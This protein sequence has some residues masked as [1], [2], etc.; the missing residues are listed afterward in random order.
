MN[1]NNTEYDRAEIGIWE[2]IEVYTKSWKLVLIIVLIFLIA[3][4][5]CSLF[6]NSQC[7]EYTLTNQV[8]YKDYDFY[9]VNI[10]NTYEKELIKYINENP[11]YENCVKIQLN[12]EEDEVF[13]LIVTISHLSFEDA[14]KCVKEIIAWNNKVIYDEITR[15]I[16]IKEEEVNESLNKFVSDRSYYLEFLYE[17]NGYNDTQDELNRYNAYINSIEKQL[18]AR[19]NML[20]KVKNGFPLLLEDIYLTEAMPIE[21]YQLEQI[22]SDYYSAENIEKEVQFLSEMLKEYKSN[23]LEVLKIYEDMTIENTCLK[24]N[25]NM[26][27][28][29]F[30]TNTEELTNLNYNLERISEYYMKNELMEESAAKSIIYP[31]A[32]SLIL[33]I[34]ASALFV[35]LRQSYIDYKKENN[36]IE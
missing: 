25:S 16:K 1:I 22:V 29:L 31:L 9:P 4:V 13:Y 20:S 32:I 15:L 2:L 14:Q 5:V 30:E 18:E 8:I 17:E 11:N 23:Y 12:E 34:L 27:E 10:L 7:S 33:G 35:M 26:S 21:Y 24:L 19:K 3:G 36:E 6:L 28:R